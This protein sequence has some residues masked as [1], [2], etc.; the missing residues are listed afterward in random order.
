MLVHCSGSNI[1]LLSEDEL[2]L[3]A[4]LTTKYQSVDP[5]NNT[6]LSYNTDFTRSKKVFFFS[7]RYKYYGILLSNLWH[8]LNRQDVQ[9]KDVVGLCFASIFI[10]QPNSICV[11]SREIN[12]LLVPLGYNDLNGKYYGKESTIIL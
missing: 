2:L 1:V 11:K 4:S 12:S 8:I 3:K 7:S 10:N 6:K 9:A 5:I